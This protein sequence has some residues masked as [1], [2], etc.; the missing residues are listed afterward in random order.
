[1][2]REDKG[3]ERWVKQAVSSMQLIL[4]NKIPENPLC[5]GWWEE[6]KDSWSQEKHSQVRTFLWLMN[7]VVEV[8]S[9]GTGEDIVDHC[10]LKICQ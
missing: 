4:L 1:M 5:H 6:E 2:I 7:A 9:F 3:E 10:S 8:F